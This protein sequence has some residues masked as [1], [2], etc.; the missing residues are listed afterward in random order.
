MGFEVRP[1]CARARLQKIRSGTHQSANDCRRKMLCPVLW[2]SPWGFLLIMA[3][4]EP[5]T[6]P[7]SFEEYLEVCEQWDY[8]PGEDSCPFEPKPSDW[9]GIR[10]DAW[11]SIIRR[12]HGER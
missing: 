11:R 12:L 10:A 2:M 8:L 6:E 1:Q 5:T 4:A 9:V 7:M 3:A